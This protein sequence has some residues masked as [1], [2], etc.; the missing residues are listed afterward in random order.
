MAVCQIER[1]LQMQGKWLDQFAISASLLCLIHC[2][3]LP[4]MILALPVIGAALGNSEWF[5][6]VILMVATP[7]SLYA[8]V[9]GFR[10]HGQPKSLV[11]GLI[12]LLFLFFG[13][14]I[15]HLALA[16]T[17]LTVVGSLFLAVGHFQNLR[18]RHSIIL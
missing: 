15:E 9:S 7:T 17:A 12:G 10:E 1:A 14:W 5:H 6:P 13:I 2:L 4:V 11:F 16:G 18:L 8:L 3:A